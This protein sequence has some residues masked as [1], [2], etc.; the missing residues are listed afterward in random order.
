MSE[1][2][3]CQQTRQAVIENGEV[4]STGFVAERATQPTF[5]DSGWTDDQTIAVLADPII[6]GELEEERAI[7][8]A[9]SAV[10][11]VLDASLIAHPCGFDTRVKSILL[12][13]RCL[14][15]KQETE[16]FGMIEGA[17]LRRLFE[18]PEALGH[19]VQAEA[20]EKFDGGMCQ[21]H[22]LLQWK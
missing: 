15:L 20:V 3:G 17:G 8:A 6:R 5:P 14:V 19:A 7:Q 9:R 1:R 4:L 16:P 11:D 2:Q 12:A 13:Q 10:I 22:D 21:Y 18:R